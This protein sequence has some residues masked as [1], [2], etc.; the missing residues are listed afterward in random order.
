MSRSADLPLRYQTPDAW[1]QQALCD[2]LALLNDHAHLEKKAA[3]NALELLNRWP[4]PN[5]PEYWVEKMSAIARDEVDHLAIVT[6]L[7]ARRGGRLA[8]HHRN[9]YASELRKLVRTGRGPAELL[10]RLMISAL[11][12]ARSCE[13][14][15][16]LSR[17]C[18]D[19]E[20]RR[21]YDDLWA[22][23]NGHYRIF[24][25]LARQLPD[26]TESVE[27]RWS[28]MLDAEAQIIQSQPPGAR[29]HSGVA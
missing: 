23:E 9:H 14:F 21:L 3:A 17:N 5:P 6:R 12:E 15:E 16:V 27:A 11:I 2:P 20:L 26:S 1:A 18:E 10:D 25:D 29:M 22:S 28:E 4:E 24:I 8:K 19:T 7:L 13:R